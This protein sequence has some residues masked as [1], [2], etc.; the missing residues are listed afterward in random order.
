MRHVAI[1][2]ALLGA[3]P[4]GAQGLLDSAPS[5]DRAMAAAPYRELAACAVDQNARGVAQVLKERWGGPE[6]KRRIDTLFMRHGCDTMTNYPGASRA[7]KLV[8]LSNR[9]AFLAEALLKA[10]HPDFAMR[11]APASSAPAAPVSAEAGGAI[12]ARNAAMVEGIAQCLTAKNWPAV[13][14]ALAAPYASEEEAVRLRD[15]GPTMRE[16]VGPSFTQ[17][18]HGLYLRGALAEAVFD[19][20][21]GTPRTAMR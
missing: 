7:E 13:T 1:A 6:E 12:A 9:R 8:A 17:R 16:C 18:I 21:D 19:A 2:A 3:L 4:A 15:L 20:L 5:T 10:R 14:A 11:P